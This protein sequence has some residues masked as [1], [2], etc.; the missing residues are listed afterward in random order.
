MEDDSYYVVKLRNIVFQRRS[1]LNDLIASVAMK[2]LEIPTPEPGLIRISSRFLDAFPCCHAVGQAGWAFGSRHPGHF[3]TT[4]VY[5]FVPDTLLRCVLNLAD[6]VGALVLDKW[7]AHAGKRQAIFVRPTAVMGVSDKDVYL[8]NQRF[9]ALMIGNSL[10][11]GGAEWNF[12][13]GRRAGLYS[14]PLVY[15][16]V[17]LSHCKSWIDKIATLPENMFAPVCHAIPA[18]WWRPGEKA[19]FNRVLERL[20][21]RKSLVPDLINKV[22]MRL[23]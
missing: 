1:L 15:R 2:A 21:S 13:G 19:E 11:L 10:M 8:S 17:T 12:R 23:D 22:A 9:R 20:W 18:E 3:M 16:S 6:F 14:R 4:A 7:M 5:D